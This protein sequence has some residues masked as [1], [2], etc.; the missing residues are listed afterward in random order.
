M[1]IIVPRIRARVIVWPFKNYSAKCVCFRAEIQIFACA[2]T[3]RPECRRAVPRCRPSSSRAYTHIICAYIPMYTVQYPQVSCPM[4]YRTFNY[5][6]RTHMYIVR[7]CVCVWRILSYDIDCDTP[8]WR[9]VQRRVHTHTSTHNDELKFMFLR[10]ARVLLFAFNRYY[11]FPFLFFF[12]I[13][14]PPLYSRWVHPTTTYRCYALFSGQW[15]I[16][17]IIYA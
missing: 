11:I 16:I 17:V 7:A 4:H 9:L 1:Y 6:T 2:R 15:H 5:N 3:R 14:T 10:R 12:L 13:Y 8:G